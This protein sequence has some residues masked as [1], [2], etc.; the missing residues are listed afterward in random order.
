MELLN[1]GFAI[2]L[3]K[4]AICILPGV[5]GIFLLASSE[6]KKREMRNFACNKL[7]GVSNAIPYPKFAL[8]TTVFGSCL[9][10]LSLTGTWFLLLRG[11]I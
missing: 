5:A 1:L 8:F 7:F 2:L 3:I 6:D 10:L 4:I 9:L 11:L